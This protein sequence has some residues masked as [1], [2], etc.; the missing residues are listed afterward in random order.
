[1]YKSSQPAGPASSRWNGGRASC[2]LK[3]EG[4]DANGARTPHGPKA[5]SLSVRRAAPSTQST[6]AHAARSIPNASCSHTALDTSRNTAHTHKS[7]RA[8]HLEPSSSSFFCRPLP[9]AARVEHTI[10]S[11]YL[12]PCR[13]RRRH[14]SS[15]AVGA[16]RLLALASWGVQAWRPPPATL[17]GGSPGRRSW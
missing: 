11:A 16:Q 10:R 4:R 7:G 13:I 5:S 14:F 8:T 17:P 9:A 6:S 1:M 3:R 2:S 12:S 15:V